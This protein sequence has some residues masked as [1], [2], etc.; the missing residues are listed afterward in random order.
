MQ[1]ETD[2]RAVQVVA[3]D[4][5]EASAEFL[6]MRHVDIARG[7]KT[8]L[9]D[10]NL[11]VATGEHIAILGPNGCGKSTLIKAMTCECYPIVRPGMQMKVY[12]RDRW[13]VQELRKHLGV[14]A[15]ELPGERTAVT[16]GVDAVV[17]GFFSSSTLWPNLTVT[18]EM[19]SRALDA[20][21]LLGA[22]YLRDRLVGE[23]SA[24]EKRRVMI[25]RALVPQPAMLLLDEPSNALD[26]AAQ[27]EL[28]EILRTVAAGT[29]VVMVTHHLADILPEMQ[30]V[31]MMREGRILADGAKQELLRA[32]RLQQLFGVPL[33][34]TE[35]EGYWHSW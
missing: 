18:E 35:R 15:A 34:L 13:D 3:S 8:V 11:A 14:V 1:Q 28:R 10:I 7:Q 32:D 17:S 29:G 9:Q 22:G 16:R 6:T 25:A 26:L 33:Q 31:V 12:G 21:A 5:F 23:M 30:R 4:R 2:E 27:R 24:G 20:L 19:R